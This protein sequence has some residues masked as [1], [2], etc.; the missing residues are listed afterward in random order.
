MRRP[1]YLNREPH[2]P[3]LTL[4][5]VREHYLRTDIWCGS[6]LCDACDMVQEHERVLARHPESPSDKYRFPH[7]LV[8]DTNVV[9][10]QIDVLDEDVLQNVIML[11]TVLDE[12]KH[13][14][15][16]VYKRLTD[17]LKRPARQFYVFVNEHHRL[18]G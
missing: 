9:L 4:Q 16:L 14:S 7:Y 6:S 2:L 12:V 8:L 18:V 13:K 1:V 5:I 10:D 11:H 17:I 3:L 15:L